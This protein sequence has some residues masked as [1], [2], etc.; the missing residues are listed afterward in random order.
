MV[1]LVAMGCR[2]TRGEDVGAREAG[3]GEP[4]VAAAREL[5]REPVA[6]PV[7]EPVVAPVSEPVAAAEPVVEPVV[8]P[9]RHGWSAVA[10]RGPIAGSGGPGRVE[11]ES[12]TLHYRLDVR[13]HKTGL[14]L[15]LTER[16]SGHTLVV[17]WKARLC[18]GEVQPTV[19]LGELARGPRGRRLLELGLACSSGEDIVATDGL[20]VI[21]LVDARGLSRLWTGE[22]VSKGSHVCALWQEIE[23]RVEPPE[24][25]VRELER[26]EILQPE[27]IPGYDCDESA[28]AYETVRA[29]RRVRLP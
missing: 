17:P 27:A 2:P 6:A 7:S 25:V 20:V 22:T 26:F 10:E 15:T 23:A 24:L 5:V 16:G 21:V 9:V 13:P 8:E 28:R 4:V 12:D 11:L 19:T 29:A 1:L 18:G 3:R 14:K